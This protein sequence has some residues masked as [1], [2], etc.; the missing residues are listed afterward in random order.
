MAALNPFKKS[1]K[2]P[3]PVAATPEKKE[4]KKAGAVGDVGQYLVRP[5]ITEKA[6][7][8]AAKNQY[9]FVVTK[10]ASKKE[11]EN[12]VQRLYGVK[13]EGVRIVNVRAKKM[14]LGKIKGVKKGYKKA[15]VQVKQGQ[16]IEILP[17]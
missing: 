12:S 14:R 2:K 17:T 4:E 15:I 13:V 7:D 3:E 11:I 6:T 9:V 10:K 1:E 16:A 8:L 5:H